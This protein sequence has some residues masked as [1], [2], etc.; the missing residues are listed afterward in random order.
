MA[1]RW[2][3]DPNQE[4]RKVVRGWRT[5]L[6]DLRWLWPYVSTAV[7][8]HHQG[9]FNSEGK[10]SWPQ[11]APMTQRA[12]A[13]NALISRWRPYDYSPAST[14]G[15]AHRI[16]HWTHQLRHTLTKRSG[17]NQIRQMHRMKFVFGTRQPYAD[18][19]MRGRPGLPKRPP[20]DVEG[21]IPPIQRVM[22][23]VV[24]DLFEHA[25]GGRPG[26]GMTRAR[27]TPQGE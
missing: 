5:S 12:R 14:E 7:E 1:L 2:R 24:G 16:L 8:E 4:F 17:G 15:P 25:R 20:L 23:Q 18:D 13:S 22:E 6:R 21:S 26:P 19:H 27:S 3:F 10:G 11:L 9:W